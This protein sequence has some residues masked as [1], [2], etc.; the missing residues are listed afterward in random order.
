MRLPAPLWPVTSRVFATLLLSGIRSVLSI[1]GNHPD[2]RV[3]SS[4]SSSNRVPSRLHKVWIGST[5]PPLADLIST[6]TFELLFAPERID[7]YV[8]TRMV[9]T[10]LVRGSHRMLNLSSCHAALGVRLHRFNLSDP[11]S[12]IR[13]ATDDFNIWRRGV[14]TVSRWPKAN[15]IW[16]ADAIRAWAINMFGGWYLDGDVLVLNS[17]LSRWRQCPFVVSV[18]QYDA[19]DTPPSAERQPRVAQETPPP[20]VQGGPT[21]SLHSTFKRIGMEAPLN[22]AMMAAVPNSS[23]GRAW[24]SFV[25]EQYFSAT[26]DRM[27]CCDWPAWYERRNPTLLMGAWSMRLLGFNTSQGTAEAARSML[28]HIAARDATDAIHLAN[29][30][31]RG[32][33][34]VGSV[35]AAALERAVRIKMASGSLTAAQTQCVELA[36]EWLGSTYGTESK[37]GHLW[38]S[39]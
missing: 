14:Y 25:R 20:P 3:C 9:S 24:V 23:F 10:C 35:L 27:V 5:C 19:L 2:P 15:P 17:A 33:A 12:P 22:T 34:L 16:L 37:P 11:G 13:E 38:P 39:G 30:A 18:D 8:T 36:R 1:R 7:Y 21:G 31:A 29:L 4:S 6:I 32:P 26:G 28:E